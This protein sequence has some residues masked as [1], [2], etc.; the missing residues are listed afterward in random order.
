MKKL[1]FILVLAVATFVACQKD[2]SVESSQQSEQE[3]ITMSLNLSV[4]DMSAGTAEAAEQTTTYSLT[5]S[6][7]AKEPSTEIQ[8]LWIAQFDSSG[9]VVGTPQY[10]EEFQKLATDNEDQ[11]V[12]TIEIALIPSGTEE[13]TLVYIAN[14]FNDAITQSI[15]SSYT[16]DQFKALTSTVTSEKSIFGTADDTDYYSILYG[17]ITQAISS[18]TD[19]KTCTLKRNV[20]KIN[21]NLVITD[22]VDL[23]FSEAVVRGVPNVSS[24]YPN[25]VTDSNLPADDTFSYINYEGMDITTTND[26]TF[27]VPVN[28]RGTSASTTE[29][30]K[31]QYGT[32]YCTA[33][34]LLA[35]SSGESYLY[36]FY[37]GADL[38]NDYNIAPNTEYTYTLTFNTVGDPDT[39]LRIEETGGIDYSL[40]TMARSNCYIL[41][42][43]AVVDSEYIIPID[44][45]DEFWGDESYNTANVSGNTLPEV[46]NNWEAVILWHDQTGDHYTAATETT[47]ESLYGLTLEED[48][49]N[50]TVKV[51][52]PTEFALPANHCNVVFVVRKTAEY[53]TD[54]EQDILWSWHL[55]ITDYNPYPDNL[56]PSMGLYQYPVDGGELHRYNNSIFKTGI[57]SDKLIMDRNIGARNSTSDGYGFSSTGNLYVTAGALHYQYGR[58]NP[59]PAAG[60]TYING[61]DYSMAHSSTSDVQF[62]FVESVQTP[63]G[64]LKYSGNWCNETASQSIDNIWNDYKVVANS[65][66]TGKSI[67]DPSPWGFRVPITGTWTGFSSGSADK[68]I[69]ETATATF[70]LVNVTVTDGVASIFQPYNRSYNG[71]ALYPASGFRSY[72]SASLGN[73]GS[74]GYY[75]SASPSSSAYG[76]NLYFYSTGVTT[77]NTNYRANGLPVRPVQE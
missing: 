50:N 29:Q 24:Y 40:P 65:Y 76:Y 54:G 39:D 73:V 45:I 66:T 69:L 31:N 70:K 6:T 32:P 8:N 53:D 34:S 23:T 37:L 15:G 16:I 19:L 49:T 11:S 17:E 18:S 64:H 9:K 14:T 46:G 30:M 1:A 57:Y 42:P 33:V 4:E 75:W 41:N 55:W 44:R 58:S 43:S 26:I 71:F 3:P 21:V 7:L 5:R 12:E 48:Y 10:F 22:G 72:S 25:I 59:I 62:S 52:L 60:Y 51:T 2:P 74:L 13:H 27:Y 36:T 63:Y 56:T 35:E 38:I 68:E 28:M 61:N 77:A 20:A 47:P 67:F